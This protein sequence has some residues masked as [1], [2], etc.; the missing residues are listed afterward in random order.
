MFKEIKRVQAYQKAFPYV[1]RASEYG[2]DDVLIGQYAT[3][4]EAREVAVRFFTSRIV[5]VVTNKPV[6]KLTLYNFND[7][8][9]V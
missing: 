3:V 9:S 2:K 6:E 1:V 5:N 4:K 7:K 8:D